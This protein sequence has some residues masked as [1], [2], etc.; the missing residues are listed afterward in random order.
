MAQTQTPTQQQPPR[1][2]LELHA[3]L[4]QHSG[5]VN[6]ALFINGKRETDLH[7]VTDWQLAGFK[8]MLVSLDVAIE[9][10]AKRRG[11]Q[12]TAA[13]PAATETSEQE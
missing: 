1:N 4:F 5:K 8:E 6:A 10:E 2:I 13:E 9:Q 11:I 12:R 7:R 3:Q